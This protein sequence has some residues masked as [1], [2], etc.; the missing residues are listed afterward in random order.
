MLDVP[1]LSRHPLRHQTGVM[2]EKFLVDIAPL[3]T[4]VRRQ[5]RPEAKLDPCVV[6]R[7]VTR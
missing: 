1:A 4:S 6:V 7:K 3:W 2:R 5:D